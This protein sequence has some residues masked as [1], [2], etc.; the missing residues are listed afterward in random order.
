MDPELTLDGEFQ[1]DAAFVPSVAKRK[2]QIHH[3][4]VMQ[5]YLFSQALKQVILA[6]KLHNA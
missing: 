2:L 5:T 6:T 3:F 4:K 1:F